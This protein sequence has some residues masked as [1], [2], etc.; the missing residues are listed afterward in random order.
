MLIDICLRRNRFTFFMSIQI[1][2]FSTFNLPFMFFSDMVKS[3]FFMNEFLAT[4]V[5][6]YNLVVV[7]MSCVIN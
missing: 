6:F 1:F 5:A 2:F 4:S 7:D 3:I